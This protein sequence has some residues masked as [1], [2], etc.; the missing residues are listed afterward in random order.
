MPR[1][2]TPRLARL[3]PQ[4]KE[5]DIL[6]PEYIEKLTDEAD[7]DAADQINRRTEFKVINARE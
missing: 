3:Y 1:T 6:T 5:G 4:F 7:R 2:I